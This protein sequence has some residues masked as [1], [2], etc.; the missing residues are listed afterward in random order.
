[1]PEG[2]PSRATAD[3]TPALSTIYI[4]DDDAIVRDVIRGMIE[5]EGNAV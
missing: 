3:N 5:D 1:M 4:V 2:Q